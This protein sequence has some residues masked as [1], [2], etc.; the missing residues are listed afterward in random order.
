MTNFYDFLEGHAKFPFPPVPQLDPSRSVSTT[1]VSPI[2]V[3]SLQQEWKAQRAV[4]DGQLFQKL[5]NT[6]QNILGDT[7][8]DA[9]AETYLLRNFS[10]QLE[11]DE[12]DGR[13]IRD[14]LTNPHEPHAS[15]ST[16]L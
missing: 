14:W 3:A 15:F 13:F 12:L 11:F 4:R 8:L 5:C 9:N 16:P 6:L 10:P 2:E 7:R 1:D